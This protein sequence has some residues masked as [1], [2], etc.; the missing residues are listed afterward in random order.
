MK[1]E[2][3]MSGDDIHE[4]TYAGFD[5]CLTFTGVLVHLNQPGTG[6]TFCGRDGGGTIVKYHRGN[7][8]GTCKKVADREAARLAKMLGRCG[9]E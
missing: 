4:G 9:N 1:E 2:T 3:V 5:A 6:M 8:C 7:L